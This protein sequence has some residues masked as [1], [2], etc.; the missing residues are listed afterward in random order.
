MKG[1]WIDWVEKWKGEGTDS[2]KEG[3]VEVRTVSY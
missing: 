2:W 3:E 1:I